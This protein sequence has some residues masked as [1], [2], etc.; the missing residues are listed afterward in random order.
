MRDVITLRG[1]KRGLAQRVNE[2]D[3]PPMAIFWG[4][5]DN[6]IPHAHAEQ[7][8]ALLD[9]VHVVR[10][11]SSAHY[12]HRDASDAFARELTRFLDSPIA[13]RPR[14]RRPLVLRKKRR[15]E[16]ALAWMRGLLARGED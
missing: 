6:V 3:L 11:E 13:M 5:K 7:T 10:F 4:T 8:L 16:A 2:V 12:P 14:V 1:Q 9:G 15:H